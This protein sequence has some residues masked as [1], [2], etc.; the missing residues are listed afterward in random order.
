[1]SDDFVVCLEGKLLFGCFGLF[2]YLIV[3]FIDFGWDGYVMFEFSNVVNFLI[4]IYY[5]MKIG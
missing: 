3:G 5:G 4:M 2:I 1:L